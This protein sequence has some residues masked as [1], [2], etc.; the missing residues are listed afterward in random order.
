M[1]ISLDGDAI[2]DARI[3]FGGMAPVVVRAE[4]VEAALIGR[5]WTRETLDVAQLALAHDVAPMS[6]HR[7]GADYRLTAARG[8]LER[9]WLQTRPDDPLPRAL[10]E[11]WS[12]P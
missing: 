1:W 6:D 11:I 7:G 12:R 3:A 5:A 4:H 2:T 8:L 9:F 10:T